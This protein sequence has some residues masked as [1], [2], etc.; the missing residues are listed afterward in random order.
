MNLDYH[1]RKMLYH[2]IHLPIV[3]LNP[4]LNAFLMRENGSQTDEDDEHVGFGGV[5]S[6]RLEEMNTKLR[7]A[8]L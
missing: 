4:L 8:N 6:A 3:F 5:M 2:P 7:D 1:V